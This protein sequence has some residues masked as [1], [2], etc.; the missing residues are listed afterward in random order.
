MVTE[1]RSDKM[2]GLN[3][4][5]G[6]KKGI[7]LSMVV[8]MPKFQQN[9]EKNRDILGIS[10]IVNRPIRLINWK[11]AMEENMKKIEVDMVT[12]QYVFV[13]DPE[14][15]VHT[16]RT[17]SSPIRDVLRSIPE[18]GIK[19]RDAEGGFLTKIIAKKNQKLGTTYYLDLGKE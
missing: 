15:I 10:D 1:I 18:E 6:K 4:F 13:N 7:D 17:E 12:L 3:K 2:T 5:E 14:E 19:M 16:T 11:I 8:G 9:Y